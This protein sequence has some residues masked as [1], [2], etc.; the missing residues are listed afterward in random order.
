M[1]T[2]QDI[3]R[4]HSITGAERKDHLKYKDSVVK[5]Y[6]HRLGGSRG[7]KKFA[8]R[9][10]KERREFLEAWQREREAQDALESLTGA[11]TN[12]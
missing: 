1:K 4:C 10:G 2:E 8:T 12:A 5:R 7:K 9:S 6:A 3:K 11:I